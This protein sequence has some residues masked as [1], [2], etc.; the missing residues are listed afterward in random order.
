VV[1]CR[2]ITVALLSGSAALHETRVGIDNAVLSADGVLICG[3]VR[4]LVVAE[5][6]SGVENF[7]FSAVHDTVVQVC[8]AVLSADGH[9]VQGAVIAVLVVLTG[10]VVLFGDSLATEDTVVGISDLVVSANR[11]KEVD[12]AS[13]GVFAATGSL[14]FH[15]DILAVQRAHVIVGASVLTANRV[16]GTVLTRATTSV[17]NEHGTLASESA[18]V[19]VLL[20]IGAANGGDCLRTIVALIVVGRA[21]AIVSFAEALAFQQALVVIGDSV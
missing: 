4:A 2:A 20:V 1:L 14:A 21:G 11:L 13:A 9:V 6:V 18:Q 10:S 17:F 16:K 19:V 15:L 3:T 12:W 7:N 8:Q 5:T